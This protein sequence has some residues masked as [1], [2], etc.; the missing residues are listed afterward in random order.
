MS[1]T[2]RL[3]PLARAAVL[4]AALLAPVALS[5][6]ARPVNDATYYIGQNDRVP[7]ALCAAW[8]AC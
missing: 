2:P 1:L 6:C 8:A 5:G 4:A 7:T 3:S